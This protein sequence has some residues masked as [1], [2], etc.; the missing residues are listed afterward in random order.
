MICAAHQEET[1]WGI[2]CY[3]V[4]KKRMDRYHKWRNSNNNLNILLIKNSW[5]IQQGAK[6]LLH[7]RSL[8][9]ASQEIQIKREL[10]VVLLI[11]I[12]LDEEECISQISKPKTHL[13]T[14]LVNPNPSHMA[15]EESLPPTRLDH[16]SNIQLGSL[17]NK[18]RSQSV[19]SR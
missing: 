11:S 12:P 9:T 16:S 2:K 1:L 3:Q 18:M 5:E 15:L 4:S 7:R 13:T 19:Y 14:H 8:S 17:I 6:A 10:K